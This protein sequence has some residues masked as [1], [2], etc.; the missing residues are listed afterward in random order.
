VTATST[1]AP[2]PATT[3][4]PGLIYA[5]MAAV[6]KDIAPVGKTNENREQRYR[7]RSIEDVM[8][9]VKVGLTKHGV[10]YLP[11]VTQRV[12]EQRTTAGGKP[13]NT[14]HL[15]MRYDFYA[16]D[17]SSVSAVVW[18][19]GADLADKATNKAMSAALKY[20]LVQAFSIA[21]EDIEDSDRSAEEA[22]GHQS[23]RD[24]SWRDQ[25]PVNRPQSNGNGHHANGQRANGTGNGHQPPPAAPVAPPPLAD[26]DGWKDRIADVASRDEANMLFNEIVQLHNAGTIDDRRRTQLE[27][28]LRWHMTHPPARTTA[29]PDEPAPAAEPEQPAAASNPLETGEHNPWASQPDFDPLDGSAPAPDTSDSTDW[30]EATR[31]IL[32]EAQHPDA[33]AG[34]QQQIGQ[35]IASKEITPQVGGELSKELRAARGR[36]S[37]TAGAAK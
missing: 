19:E 30:A 3:G 27:A 34:L 13:M 18:G 6:M 7:F 32:R 29:Q 15:E 21:A 17:G 22:G 24:Q 36:V 4:K 5:A 25:P 33:L 1:E 26:D 8:N 14:V 28:H 11:T 35:K 9:A 23:S 31:K 37:Q 12:P 16:A 20:A 2:A 10:F